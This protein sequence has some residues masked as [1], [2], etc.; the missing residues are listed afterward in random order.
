VVEQCERSIYAA[1]THNKIIASIANALETLQ[2][3]FL[4]R[5]SCSDAMLSMI[6]LGVIAASN[7]IIYY[8]KYEK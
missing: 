4:D 2:S 5:F 1:I 6:S 7:S 8:S 3:H